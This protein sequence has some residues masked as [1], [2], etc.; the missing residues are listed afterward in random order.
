MKPAEGMY[1][2]E[3]RYFRVKVSSLENANIEG[4]DS[5]HLLED[6]TIYTAKARDISSFRGLSPWYGT[7]RK[8]QELGRACINSS[9]NRI[10]A[11]NPKRRG[12][13]EHTQAV[14]PTHSRGVAEVM[15]SEST[16][17]TRRGWQYYVKTK[18]DIIDFRRGVGK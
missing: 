7:A 16:L 5:V 3:I 18:G 15:L 1:Q 11:N 12:S 9:S 10:A 13:S 4:V 8:L 6:R 14:G 2:T 17:D